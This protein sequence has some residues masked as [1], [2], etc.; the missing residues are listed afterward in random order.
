MADWT[1]FAIVLGVSCWSFGCGYLAGQSAT[2]V[3]RLTS[4]PS[5]REG[6]R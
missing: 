4:L 5:V 2:R 1:V 3:A 6:D